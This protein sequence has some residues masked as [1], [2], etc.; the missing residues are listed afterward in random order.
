MGGG[1][2]R[3]ITLRATG[4]RSRD[5]LTRL[6][7][8]LSSVRLRYGYFYN[9][10]GGVALLSGEELIGE[11]V[12]NIRSTHSERLLPPALQKLLSDGDLKP[13][14][15]G[16]I[17][18]VTGPGSFTGLRIGVATAKGLSYALRLPAVGGSPL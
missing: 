13:Q 8:G 18:A 2:E 15:L 16:L 3:E 5:V 17:C 1:E 4:G 9:D 6:G 10:W 14:D 7:G 12:L 11:S